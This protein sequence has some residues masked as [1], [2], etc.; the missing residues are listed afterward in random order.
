[1]KG[2]LT[3]NVEKSGPVTN[4][5]RKSL[6]MSVM[7]PFADPIYQRDFNSSVFGAILRGMPLKRI[8]LNLLN[9]FLKVIC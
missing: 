4:H 3:D 9:V 6:T 7:K 8:Q 1:M 2:S 5:L